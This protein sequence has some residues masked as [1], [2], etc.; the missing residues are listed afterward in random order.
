MI[1]KNSVVEIQNFVVNQESQPVKLNPVLWYTKSK[2]IM[3]MS[4]K[5]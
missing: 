3:K 5:I 1:T 2:S 4:S